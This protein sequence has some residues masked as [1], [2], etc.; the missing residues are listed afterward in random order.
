MAMKEVEVA[1]RARAGLSNTLVG[2]SL[3]QE[4]FKKPKD[5][6]DP[7]IG[8][9]LWQPGSEPGEAVALMELFTGAIGLFK[10]PVSHR[11]VDLTDPAEAAEI[12]LLAGL[13]LRLVTKIPPSASS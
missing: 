10:N 9:P 12:V 5:S 2:T 3:M 11:R 1:V 13:L 4:A 6:N 7:A 8:G